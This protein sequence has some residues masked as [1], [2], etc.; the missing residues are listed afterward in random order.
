MCMEINSKREELNVSFIPTFGEKDLFVGDLFIED[1]ENRYSLSEK[2]LSKGLAKRQQS[3][4]CTIFDKMHSKNQSLVSDIKPKKRLEMYEN[5]STANNLITLKDLIVCGYNLKPFFNDINDTIIK[6]VHKSKFSVQNEDLND[7]QKV[8][9]PQICDLKHSVIIS[10]KNDDLTSLYLLPMINIISGNNHQK[11]KNFSGTTAI[12]F[13]PNSAKIK[14]ILAQCEKYAPHLRIVAA[15]GMN[16]EAKY[17]VLNG[18]DFLITTPPAYLRIFENLAL[19]VINEDKLKCIIFHDFSQDSLTQFDQEISIIMRTRYKKKIPQTLVVS[20]TVSKN[21][22]FKILKVLDATETVFLFDNY[23]DAAA[24]VGLSI[25]IEVSHTDKGKLENLKKN[26]MESYEKCIIVVNDSNLE[27]DLSMKGVNALFCDNSKIAKLW[28]ESNSNKCVLITDD[29]ILNDS[30][31]QNANYLIHFDLPDNKIN[32]E[33]INDKFSKRFK[34]FEK[35]IQRKLASFDEKEVLKTKII[36]N[37]KDVKQFEGLISYL[38][39]REILS[40]N[41]DVVKVR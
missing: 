34:T 1:R 20:K 19:D 39:A 13:A 31:V 7:I 23:L 29:T 14:K 36:L 22:K 4:F 28:D 11:N 3:D 41:D 25:S 32:Q 24:F 33:S 12:I 6:T 27:A 10:S 15:S 30:S 40:V 26:D 38:I 21:L 16:K 17:D 5:S 9:W 18:C 8:I 35:A 2:F 37:D